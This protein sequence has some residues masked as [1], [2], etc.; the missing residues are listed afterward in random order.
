MKEKAQERETEREKQ[1]K[2]REG[3]EREN[4]MK[5]GKP[6]QG[7]SRWIIHGHT[8]EHSIISKKA[9]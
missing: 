8:E 3:G 6:L 9:Q 7:F 5:V 2:K 4:K 1:K